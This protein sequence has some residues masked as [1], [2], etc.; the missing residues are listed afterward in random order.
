VNKQDSGINWEEQWKNFSP[1]FYDG[2]SHIDL[3]PYNPQCTKELLLKA[4]GGFGDLSHP[5]TRLCL[6]LM[7]PFVKGAT[8]VDIGCGSGI[9]MLSGL[10]MGARHAI[11]IDIE[12]DALEHAAA[13]A[14]LNHLA[15]KAVFTKK[16]ERKHLGENLLFLMN[17]ISS[18]QKMAWEEQKPLH[19][20]KAVLVTSGIL[21]EQ[22]APYLNWAERQ[23]WKTITEASEEGWSGF[24]FTLQEGY[25]PS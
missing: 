4:G 1:A 9:L 13:N 23:G 16:I 6:K 3:S 25:S 19:S 2:A 7:A 20:Q 17:M 11:G 15:K 22:R 21:T 5:T 8:I 14:K 10:L 18:E 24:V 12:E